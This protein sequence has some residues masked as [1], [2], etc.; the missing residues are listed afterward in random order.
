MP[1]ET[2]AN[3]AWRYYI[4]PKASSGLLDDECGKWMV[5]FTEAEKA[6]AVCED[7]VASGSFAQAKHS[8]ALS[9]ALSRGGRGVMCL[10]VNGGDAEGQKKA[11]RFIVERGLV[12]KAKSGKLY[13]M[14]F[15]YDWQTRTN[16]YGKG[17]HAFLHLSDFVDLTTR[18][19]KEA[20]DMSG[21]KA[22][23][24]ALAKLRA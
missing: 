23:Q 2:R 10:Y 6:A 8:S 17:F 4:D 9:V 22:A 11:C 21:A 13:D 18:E 14:P 7:A 19:I 3:L 15:K 20:P 24:E 5:F 12:R 1:V 16:M